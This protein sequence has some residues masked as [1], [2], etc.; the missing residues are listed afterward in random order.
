M[1]H[2][3]ATAAVAIA[4]VAEECDQISTMLTHGF[5]AEG[6]SALLVDRL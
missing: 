1:A 6:S 3:P 4:G 2:T 5:A